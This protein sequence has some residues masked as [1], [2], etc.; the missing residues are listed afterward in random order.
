MSL[1]SHNALV[2][3]E[4]IRQTLDTAILSGRLPH[5]VIL[6]GDDGLG[7]RKL[8]SL[9]AASLVCTSPRKAV[10]DFPCGICPAC[11][12]AKAGSH[13]DIRILEG[14]GA[15][16]NIKVGDMEFLTEDCYRKPEEADCSVYII[17]ITKGLEPAAQN[18][19]LKVIEEPPTGTYFIFTISSAERLLS[20]IR[21]RSVILT[22]HP[23]DS[24]TAAEYVIKETGCDSEKAHRAAEIYGG[25]IGRMIRWVK[26]EKTAQAR[27]IAVNMA[28]LLTSGSEHELLSAAAPLIRDGALWS[29]TLEVLTAI[30]RDACVLRSGGRSLLGAE[31]N[32][33]RNLSSGFAKARLYH[34]PE[35]CVKYRAFGE[36]NANK[37]L[38]VTNFCLALRNALKN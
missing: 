36:Q 13:P 21:S 12:R 11:I 5:A 32:C 10:G 6:Q 29:E 16:G 22:L 34:L 25:N 3:N 1:A 8:A 17:P 33:A 30:F 26:G 7:K 9:I 31:E 23:C 38:M 18:K 24:E 19:L 15:G 27:D 28:E 20:T 4:D 35:I 14:T 37:K 2:G